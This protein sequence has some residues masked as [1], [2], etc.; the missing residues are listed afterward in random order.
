MR[1]VLR[2]KTPQH[3]RVPLLPYIPW[4]MQHYQRVAVGT[5]HRFSSAKSNTRQELERIVMIAPLLEAFEDFCRKA[6]CSEVR[7]A[8]IAHHRS[9][10]FPLV[11]K[12]S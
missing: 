8:V 1:E 12:L 2:R 4:K 6:L 10:L 5:M 9:V 7:C 3:E 11:R